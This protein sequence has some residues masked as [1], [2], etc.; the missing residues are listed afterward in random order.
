MH[1]MTLKMSMKQKPLKNLVN[2][3]PVDDEEFWD[4]FYDNLREWEIEYEEGDS[5]SDTTDGSV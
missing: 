1:G 3:H 5:G 4:D 2:E